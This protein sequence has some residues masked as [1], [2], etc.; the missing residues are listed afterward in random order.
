ML[1]KK[2]LRLGH[3]VSL[4]ALLEALVTDANR[5]D[6]DYRP[7]VDSLTYLV[8]D[9]RKLPPWVDFGCGEIGLILSDEPC[10]ELP[11]GTLLLWIQ[12]RARAPA[13]A[14]RRRPLLRPRR[15]S[16]C[17]RRPTIRSP[18]AR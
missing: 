2:L 17:G 13:R 16:T 10:P 3:P 5:R 11:I 7:H 8:A 9:G 15:A 18:S 6:G 14:R 1:R 4:Q 12:L